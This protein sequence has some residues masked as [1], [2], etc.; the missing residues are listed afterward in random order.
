MMEDAGF[1]S[2]AAALFRY[3]FMQRAL[4]ACLCM[5]I[6]CP[7]IGIFLVLRRWSLMGDTLAHASLAGAA[8]GLFVGRNPVLGAFVFTSACGL[9]VEWLRTYFRKYTELIL[10]VALALSV[11]IAVTLIS[12]GELH[13]NADAFL[14][15]SVLTVTNGDLALVAA[16]TAAA[17]ALVLR[18]RR[19]LLYIAF[20]EEAARIA[21]VRVKLVNYLFALLVAAAVAVSIRIVGVL[22]L[23]SMI[24]MPVAAAL[25]L[26][27]GFLATFAASIAFSLIDGIAGLLLS[28][29]LSAAP[30]GFT[31][32]A[33]VAMLAIVMLAMRLK[34]LA[35]S[36]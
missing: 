13:A 8:A 1:L 36:S 27:R 35:A 21:G 34:R 30:G 5:S 31:A 4:G 23:S 3:G 15:G 14:F 16:L 26:R 33:S 6:L 9:F 24:A 22:V 20:D 2:A 19:E 12:S 17:V 10:A 25:Q 11:G 29:W 18:F 32:L 28:Y 7:M